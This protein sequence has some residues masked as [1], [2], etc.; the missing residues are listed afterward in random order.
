MKLVA[1][2]SQTVGPFFSIGLSHLCS[3][4]AP[5]E[6]RQVTVHGRVIDG[7]GD[8]VSDAVLE[9]WRA[10]PSG[11]YSSTPSDVSSLASGFTRVASDE[12]GCFSFKTCRPGLV[13]FNGV[14]RQAPHLVVLVFAR[15]LLR[16]LITRMYFPDEPSN[17]ADPVLHSV[18]PDRRKTVTAKRSLVHPDILK[19]DI[20]LQGEDETVFFAW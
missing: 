5:V 18:P 17:G 10:D 4:Q 3:S 6:S 9:V 7:N 19:W 13:D 12:R 1:T 16:Q 20:V 14:Q 11:R 2:G 8:P 15:G